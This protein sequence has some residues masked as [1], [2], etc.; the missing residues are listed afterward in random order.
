LKYDL[1]D[2]KMDFIPTRSSNILS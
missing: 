2:S 1:L